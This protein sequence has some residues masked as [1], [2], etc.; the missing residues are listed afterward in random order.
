VKILLGF[1][2]FWWYLIYF[3]SNFSL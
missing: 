1:S 3:D 2:V